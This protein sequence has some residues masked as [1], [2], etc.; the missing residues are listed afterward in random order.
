MEARAAWHTADTQ[1][2][3][4]GGLSA[5]AISSAAA[6]SGTAGGG[7]TAIL[8]SSSVATL[9]L[10][11]HASTSMLVGLVGLGAKETSAAKRCSCGTIS[12]S[13]TTA[14]GQDQSK[15]GRLR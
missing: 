4:F 11:T 6:R 7:V 10:C 5:V 15:A 1:A 3:S 2:T 8:V 13:G 12:S 9:Q 14:G